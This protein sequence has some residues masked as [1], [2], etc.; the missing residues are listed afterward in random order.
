MSH[1]S[2]QVAIKA[3]SITFL[4]SYK[5]VMEEKDKVYFIFL[6]ILETIWY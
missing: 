3:S 5:K 4:Y 6:F 1:Q 2:N